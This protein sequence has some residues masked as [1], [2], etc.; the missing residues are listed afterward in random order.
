M[1]YLALLLTLSLSPVHAA[2]VLGTY[3]GEAENGDTKT[4]F[5]DVLGLTYGR[6][7]D[8]GTPCEATILV[9]SPARAQQP[10]STL[11]VQPQNL[12]ARYLREVGDDINRICYYEA[13]GETYAR[14]VAGNQL[15]PL[16]IQVRVDD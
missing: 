8:E 3:H 16:T 5:Y 2:Q 6:T 11:P 10:Q 7:L 9:D 15:C 1:R 12:T 14:S 4:C 13:R